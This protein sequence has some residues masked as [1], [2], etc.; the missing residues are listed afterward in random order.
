MLAVEEE[1]G[2]TKKKNLALLQNNTGSGNFLLMFK[3]AWMQGE[4]HSRVKTN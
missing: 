2:K 1:K 4:I 3:Y